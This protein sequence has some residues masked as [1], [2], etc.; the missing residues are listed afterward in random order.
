MTEP[1]GTFTAT[2][3]ISNNS[4]E[5]AAIS[6]LSDSYTLSAECSGLV[7]TTVAPGASVSCDYTFTQTSSGTYTNNASVTLS[8]DDGNPIR[9]RLRPA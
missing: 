8:D 2:L 5:S 1:G 9:Q 6:A 7:G 4:L 3:T